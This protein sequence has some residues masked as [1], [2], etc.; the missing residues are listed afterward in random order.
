VFFC[1]KPKIYWMATKFLVGKAVTS[2]LNMPM[3]N[4]RGNGS[5][6]IRQIAGTCA[7]EYLKIG[8]DIH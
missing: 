2:N 4:D 5:I 1:Q 3:V 6:L 8:R 7:F